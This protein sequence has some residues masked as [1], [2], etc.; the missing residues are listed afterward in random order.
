MLP[1]LLALAVPAADAAPTDDLRPYLGVAWRP[2]SRQDLVFVDEG[3][4]SGVAVGEFDG[5]VKPNFDGF[6]GLWFSRHV[7]LQVGIGVAQVVQTSVADEVASQ[8]SWAVVRPSLDLRLG[9]MEPTMK[10]PVPWF[11]VGA[12]GDVPVVTDTSTGYTAEEQSAA[13]EAATNAA[14]RLGGVGGRV[15]VG[16][17][18]RVLP[19]VLLGIHLNLGI[20]RSAYQGADATFTSLWLATEGAIQL[21][22]EWPQ[23]PTRDALLAERDRRRGIAP[24]PAV[25]PATPLEPAPEAD[26]PSEE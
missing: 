10:W 14:Y 2:L 23:G 1:L 3:R 21:T 17:D 16:V 22:F 7:S 20:V 9:W 6:V 15:G 19:G 5:S 13:D 25:V 4:T 12:F 26:V 8:K 11:S 24:A 18:Q